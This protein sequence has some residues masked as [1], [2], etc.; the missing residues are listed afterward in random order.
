MKMEV[1]KNQI[2]IFCI[3]MSCNQNVPQE[4]H[5]VYEENKSCGETI[6]CDQRVY[7]LKRFKLNGIQI[8]KYFLILKIVVL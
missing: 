5:K 7:T 4:I 2:C 6:Y 3:N 1:K 8:M